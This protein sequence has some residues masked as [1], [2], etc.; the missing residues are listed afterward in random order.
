MLPFTEKML[1]YFN[2]LLHYAFK[3]IV[4][5]DAFIPRILISTALLLFTYIAFG[6][7]E[8]IVKGR[9]T[10][11][12]KPESLPF[13]SVYI[14]GTQ[15]GTSS[16]FEGRFTLKVST[17][18]DSIVFSYVGYKTVTLKIIL[19]QTQTLKVEMEPDNKVFQDVVIVAGENPAL[20][21]VKKAAE[22]KSKNNQNTL[23]S[24][25]FDS[26]TK[27]DISMNNITEKMKNNKLFKPLKSLFD[28]ANQI[29]ND[30]GKYILPI[31]VSETY[32]HFY[33]NN[34][35][36]LT[37][38]VIKA[39]DINGFLAEQGSY[40]LDILGSSILEFNFNQNWIGFLGKEFLSPIADG[41][42]NYYIYTLTD[43]VD[44][45][46]DKCYKI[47]LNLRR[48]EDL[49]FL[50]TIWIT[51]ESFALKR[52][53][54][55][56]AP[57][58]N[59][60]FVERL[61]IQ[62]EMAKTASG[63]WLP[64]KTRGILDLDQ[65]TENSSSFIAKMYRS[66][67]NFTTNDVKPP[68]FYDMLIERDEDMLNRDSSYWD[69]VR[70]EPFSV[71]EQQMINMIDS[72]KNVPVVK[73]YLDII[74]MI[75]EGYYRRGKIDLGPT[76]LVVGYNQVEHWR[77]RLGF[78]TNH[79]FNQ[80]WYY[81]AY[82]AYG[83][84]DDKFKYGA[85]LD[86]VFSHKKWTMLTLNYKNDYEILG[87]QDPYNVQLH[88]T[89]AGNIFTSL[90]F[91]S[92]N[93]RLNYTVDYRLMLITQPKRNWTFKT[94]LQ[95]TY[96]KPAGNFVFAY[97]KEPSQAATPDNVKGDFTTTAAT[98]EARFAYKEVL[99][100]RGNERIRMVTSRLP[101]ITML[102]SKGFRNVLN[103]DF[104]FQKVQVNIEQNLI[105]G[106]FGTANFSITAG[107]VF[108]TLPYPLLE[109]PRG[110]ATFIYSNQNFSL[111]NLYEFAADEYY[112]FRYVQKFEG[113]FFN[114]IPLLD[115]WKL[116]NFAVV[117]GVYG[118]LSDR[119]KAI[120]SPVDNQGRLFS[121]IN[122]FKDIPYLE[123]GFGIENIF[124]LVKVGYFRRFTYLD[125]ANA[126]KWGI[127]VGFEFQF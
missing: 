37:K 121:P 65:L 78:K 122:E 95:N 19:G 62:Q 116:R 3:S 72:V 74:Q 6:Q 85:G 63:K 111:M 110:S 67:S 8:T 15:K 70:T 54:L 124:R 107:K 96:F 97:K 4:E 109:V 90:N 46:G 21:I 120:F 101:M 92:A 50:G 71:T 99:I 127:N 26:Y 106:I 36:P 61:K 57:S 24:F 69:S 27:I 52:V 79:F 98:L 114:R 58:A 30:E 2:F 105:T 41:G 119:N 113:L 108:G 1:L 93:A 29:K 20:R 7:Q 23:I 104:D 42:N 38:E 73:T 118:S 18:M 68:Q 86:H 22:N 88:N 17:T 77:V 66:N 100:E 117:K 5:L 10:E 16:D 103:G 25:D 11:K 34:N 9:I 94:T 81:R 12:G 125:H 43:S 112:S 55:E 31:F 35:P 53:D 13:V 39:S 82:A 33:Q 75:A 48:E 32:S 47:K 76:M 91:L 115:K 87:V 89:A 83:F 51:D 14:K 45:D 123:A 80:N 28:T 84:N 60:N 44:I 59:V 49:G 56:L 102:Y 126:H 64:A 40:V